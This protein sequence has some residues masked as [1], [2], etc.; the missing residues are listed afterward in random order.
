MA[1]RINQ[2]A[3]MTRTRCLC[4]SQGLSLSSE[5][6]VRTIHC[7]SKLLDATKNKQKLLRS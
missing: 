5:R 6:G 2:Y 3:A 4:G 7:E 1:I